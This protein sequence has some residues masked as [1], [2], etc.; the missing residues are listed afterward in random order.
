MTQGTTTT[1]ETWDTAEALPAL[2][3][4]GATRYIAG[5]DGL[6]IEQIDG[7]GSVQ[8]YLRDQLG[9]TRALLDGAGHT[10]ATYSYDAYGNPTTQTG[11]ASTPFGYAG[12]YTDA[13]TGLQY[14]QARY[15]DPA[16]Q[17]FVSVDP[18]VDQTKQ[19]YAYTADD[20][21]NMIDPTGL[22]PSGGFCPWEAVGQATGAALGAV[23]G[24]VHTGYD[25]ATSTGGSFAS[26]IGTGAVNTYY[27]LAEA[28]RL[29][30]LT[31][32][33][34]EGGVR[35]YLLH[36]SSDL[37]DAAVT[38]NHLDI[39]WNLVSQSVE[40]PFKAALAC[41]SAT[42]IGNATGDTLGNLALI[43]GP[44][45]TAGLV[46]GALDATST[47][48]VLTNLATRAGQNVPRD[49][50]SA[51]VWGTLVHSDFQRQIRA[52]NRNDL[53]TEVRYLNGR[54]L[55]TGPRIKGE[56]RYD[57]VAY[58]RNGNITAVYDLKT[59]AAGLTPARVA[60]LQAHLPPG[61]QNATIVEIRP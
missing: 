1:A 7:N 28:A 8:Y 51:R 25:F 56:V 17:Q 18:L 39:A 5:P 22:C 40:A 58:D 4:D 61:S 23:G 60:Q 55:T 34:T 27:T 44:A 24:A 59:G 9:S 53:S 36:A 30:P 31:G 46:R 6:P 43:F 38:A 52:L 14:L 35:P 10:V 26:T 57:V 3:Q 15:Y 12:E 20:P 13:E 11:S 37:A 41:P 50:L 19:P 21:L 49:N 32:P 33:F 2:L 54:R 47:T 29:I 48:R 42:T 45:K 16:T